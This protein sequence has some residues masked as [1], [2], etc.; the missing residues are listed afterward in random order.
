MS[1]V[2]DHLSFFYN[3]GQ[4]DEVKALDDITMTM[5]RHEYV[6]IIGHTGSGKST[7][8][9]HMN[10]LNLPQ[11]GTLTVDGITTSDPKASLITL[12]QR[13]GLVFQYP[14]DQLFEETIFKDVAYGPKNLKLPPEEIDARVRWALQAVGLDADTIGKESPFEVSGGQ[15]RR[16]AIAGV[17]ALRPSYLILDEPTAGLDPHGREEIL[18]TI[19]HLY[20]T[21]PDM[22]IILVTHSMEDI[23]EHAKRII[24]V[25]Q[26]KLVMD[27]TPHA[28]FARRAEL[29]AIG[30]SVPQVTL[31]MQR[32]KEEGLSVDASAITV[33]EAVSALSAFLQGKEA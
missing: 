19:H 2:F 8:V 32:L 7:L 12:R 20:D 25:D 13:V 6:G 17:L 10:G 33:E 14:E 9:Q 24:V 18:S 26:G 16:V 22:T 30:L 27:D 11:Q 31:L 15:K 3:K 21:N 28:V 29:E 4:K 1:M 23:A 5:D